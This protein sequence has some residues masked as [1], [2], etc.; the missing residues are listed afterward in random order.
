MNEY[1]KRFAHLFM[2]FFILAT[3][4][5]LAQS[6][7]DLV[8]QA[9]VEGGATGTTITGPLIYGAKHLQAQS[10]SALLTA[11]REEY[12]D[13]DY[14]ELRYFFKWF[15]LNGDGASEAIVHVVSPRACGTGGC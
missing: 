3:A 9:Q 1:G 15:D 11:L 14:S 6:K 12:N 10:D 5:A 2:A 4:S 8:K 13:S 7:G